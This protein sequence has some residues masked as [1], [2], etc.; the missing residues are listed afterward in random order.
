M[1]T[2]ISEY[3][4]DEVIHESSNSLVYRGRREA[5]NQSIVLKMLKQTYP[6]P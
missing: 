5:D 4:V 1:E 6:P 3:Q 2:I